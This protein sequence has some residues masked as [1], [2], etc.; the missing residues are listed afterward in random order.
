MIAVIGKIQ[1]QKV[2]SADRETT[3]CKSLAKLGK[4]S[5]K[6]ATISGCQHGYYLELI[7]GKDSPTATLNDAENGLQLRRFNSCDR[8]KVV[9]T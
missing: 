7:E 9:G 4:T 6:V 1:V 3:L 2:A 5:F 8:V